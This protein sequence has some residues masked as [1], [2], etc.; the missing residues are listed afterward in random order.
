[1]W[2][3]WLKLEKK[4]MKGGVKTEVIGYSRGNYLSRRMKPAKIE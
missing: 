1:M 3:V 2:V 4:L